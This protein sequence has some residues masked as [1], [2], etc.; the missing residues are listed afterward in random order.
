MRENEKP[1]VGALIICLSQLVHSTKKELEG[2]EV[3]PRLKFQLDRAEEIIA[4]NE[5]AELAAEVVEFLANAKIDVVIDE[6]AEPLDMSDMD[7]VSRVLG[8]AFVR[9]VVEKSKQGEDK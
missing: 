4:T 9:S 7:A 1:A 8:D 6:D 3:S 5:V 2:H